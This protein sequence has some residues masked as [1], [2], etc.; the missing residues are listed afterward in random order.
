[1]FYQRHF[2]KE[3]ISGN[4]PDDL[5]S[6]CQNQEALVIPGGL[7][8]LFFLLQSALHVCFSLRHFQ[9]KPQN[10]RLLGLQKHTQTTL[11]IPLWTTRWHKTPNSTL[12]RFSLF[13]RNFTGS[14]AEQYLTFLKQ[15]RFMWK[16]EF[17]KIMNIFLNNVLFFLF[18]FTFVQANANKSKNK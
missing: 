2:S 12:T 11:L 18:F 4:F 6:C 15:Y 9:L 16:W 13:T 14:N 1:M 8:L 7:K 5:I 17:V 3:G 10:L